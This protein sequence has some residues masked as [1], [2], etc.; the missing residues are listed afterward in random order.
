MIFRNITFFGMVKEKEFLITSAG[1]IGRLE[2][3]SVLE[4]FPLLITVYWLILFQER[5]EL[6][7]VHEVVITWWQV[8]SIFFR[9]YFRCCITKA[10]NTKTYHEAYKIS[11][12]SLMAQKVKNLPTMQ[13]TKVLSLGLED[14]LWFFESFFS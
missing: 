8:L 4:T 13:E 3:Q 5:V 11:W 2:L 6:K 1:L 10:H 9:P 14:F 7:K 12:A